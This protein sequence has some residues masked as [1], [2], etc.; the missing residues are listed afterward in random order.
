MLFFQFLLPDLIC[1]TFMKKIT[2]HSK[3]Q[4]KSQS[5]GK[6]QLDSVMTEKL[7]LWNRETIINTSE[8]LLNIQ[9]ERTDE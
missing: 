5:E 6:K 8:A 9:Y 1:S 2:K 4:E 3:R 7:G